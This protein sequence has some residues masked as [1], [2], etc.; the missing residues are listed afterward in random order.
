MGKLKVWQ[1][2]NAVKFALLAPDLRVVG[3]RAKVL[4]AFQSGKIAA[5]AVPDPA[6]GKP[7]IIDAGNV[8]EVLSSHPGLLGFRKGS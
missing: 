7:L 6:S 4:S 8:E 5:A 3:R 2:D 1:K